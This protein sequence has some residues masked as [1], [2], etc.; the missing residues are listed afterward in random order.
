MSSQTTSKDQRAFARRIKEARVG[1]PAAQYDVALMY[2][3]GIGVEKSV[4]QA[5]SWTESA[6]KKGHSAAQFLLGT[7]YL[8]S[9]GV[10]RDTQQALKWLVKAT[11][12]GSDKAPLRLA[13][14]VQG[15]AAS[16]GAD[17]MAIAAQRGVAEAQLHMARHWVVDKDLPNDAGAALHWCQKAAEQGLASAQVILAEWLEASGS[18]VAHLQSETVAPVALKWYRAAAKQGH[19]GAQLALIRFDQ[20]GLA[21][22]G[23]QGNGNGA[24]G[25]VRKFGARERRV[26]DERWDN[27]SQH[28][29][30]QE[31]FQMGLLYL[32]GYGPLKNAKSARTWFKKAAEAGHVDAQWTLAQELSVNSPGESV[33]WYQKAAAQGH[34]AAQLALARR[35]E[36]GANQPVSAL[37][38]LSYFVQAAL[39]GNPEAQHELAT[40]LSHAGADLDRELQIASAQAGLALAQFQVG[41]R[42]AQGQ[43]VEQ[44]WVMAVSWFR[45]AVDQ[46]NADAQCALGACYAEGLGVKKDLLRA[47][48][49]YEG[50]AEQN[51]APAQWRL[52]E[53]LARGGVGIAPDARR[54]TQYCKRSANAGFAAAQSTMAVLLA[55]AK[56]YDRAVYWW[57]LAAAQ[58]DPEALFNLSHALRMGWAKPER[59]DQIISLLFRAA[60]TGLA[61]AQARLGLC[62]AKGEEVPVD[63]VEAAKWFEL[64]AQRGDASA[65]ANRTRSQSNLSA[66]EWREAQ[67]RARDWVP[68]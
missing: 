37:D 9:L 21:R 36:V 61:A 43:G 41:Q 44:D 40:F 51:H 14:F 31:H 67:R 54:A 28:A 10:K 65:I 59:D 16:I 48:D 35:F 26:L 34:V 20:L 58:G 62:Y 8:G 53:L 23:E 57:K 52:G 13:K 68:T 42:Y 12:S 25:S 45:K 64:A 2:A 6:A 47:L 27:Y 24:R 39:V 46:G 3:N 60:Q 29:G 15:E 49:L 56:K 18:G 32:Y 11:E 33:R 17:A 4:E 1:D 30:P 50:A 19:P 38:T 63:L 7:A 55:N 22:S 66:A 5:L